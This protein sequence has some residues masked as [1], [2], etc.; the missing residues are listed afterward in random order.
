MYTYRQIHT[1]GC[2]KTYL[3]RRS[4]PCT[5]RPAVTSA[6]DEEEEEEGEEEARRGRVAWIFFSSI[7][8]SLLRDGHIRTYSAIYSEI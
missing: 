1:Y 6:A 5:V 7:P 3:F 2:Y 8:V 4:L